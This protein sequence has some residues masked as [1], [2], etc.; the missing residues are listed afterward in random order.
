MTNDAARDLEEIFDY[1]ERRDSE[2]GRATYV[3]DRIE[4]AFRSLS[5]FPRQ[6]RYP[7]ELLEIGVREYR[8]I[9]SNPYRI[10]YRVEGDAVI[11]LLI[12]DG[13]RN[14]RSLLERRLLR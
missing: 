4:E 7:N 2:G 13:R 11:I 9:S 14:M 12:A 5:E 1:I 6:G 10:I 3:L 8:E